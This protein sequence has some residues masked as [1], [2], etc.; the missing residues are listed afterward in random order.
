M[1]LNLP[2]LTMTC[3]TVLGLLLPSMSCGLLPNEEA[4]AQ[5]ESSGQRGGASVAVET[6]VAKTSS[7]EEPIAYTGTTQPIRLVSLRSQA[8]GR[9]VSLEVDVGD[10]VAQGQPLGRIDD[11][12]LT[13]Q[14]NQAEAELAAL[15]SEVAQAEAG[16]S[17]ARAQVE[18]A[19]AQLQQAQSDADR[20]KLLFE[21]GAGTAQQAEQART[22]V[23]T[24]QQAVRSAE[25]QVRTRQQAVVAAQGRVEAQRSVVSEEAERRQYSL[26][27]SPLDGA[28]LERV[29]EPGNLVQPGDA[30]LTL[31]DFSAI[32]V[33]VQVSE[34]EL[35]QVQTGQSV[36]V[37]LD[38][39]PEQVF[40]GQVSRI[41]PAADPTARLI[42]IEITMPN[43]GGRIGSGLLA[44]VQFQSEQSE[45]VV[46]P[47]TALAAAGED[48][49]STLFILEG[50]GET[51]KA[52][53]R[54]IQIGNRANGLVEVRSGLEP[55]ETF[56]A[57]SSGPLQDGQAVRLSVLSETA[58]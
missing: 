45:G 47:E 26:L 32:K 19:Q 15:R 2:K 7:L 29:S 58:Q 44:R 3:L 11:S 30:V 57:R 40:S 54:S 14:L 8:E 1:N 53:A 41:S 35:S 28:V 10:L 23:V 34:L 51:A 21:E 17:D 12:L 37:R 6:A 49:E 16:V 33:M 43:L 38:A 18:Q 42:P 50:S 56:V 39:F 4:Q 25:E 27:T 55:G 31:G 52:V 46:I 13:A 5:S 22:A 9:L 48:N 24:T 20:L 36:Q